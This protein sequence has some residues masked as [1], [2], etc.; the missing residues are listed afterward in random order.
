V[1]RVLRDMIEYVFVVASIG[2]TIWVVLD[3]LR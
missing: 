2:F 3:T 1:S